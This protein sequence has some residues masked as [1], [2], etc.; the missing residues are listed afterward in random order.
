MGENNVTPRSS[1]IIRTARVCARISMKT[2]KAKHSLRY[3]G[4]L[5]HGEFYVYAD[6]PDMAEYHALLRIDEDFIHPNPA[7]EL[8]NLTLTEA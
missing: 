4:V 2:Y 3:R 1:I 5:H 7:F 6:S 8:V